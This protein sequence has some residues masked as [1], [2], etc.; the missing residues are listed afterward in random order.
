M[1]NDRQRPVDLGR[2]LLVTVVIRLIR[3]RT[4][5]V[6]LGLAVIVGLAVLGAVL[7]EGGLRVV[8]VA[9]A[10][11]VGVVLL[12][13]LLLR[14]VATFVVAKLAPPADLEA[15]QAA[16]DE[17]VE[18]LGLPLG[19]IS[20]PRFALR[21]RKGVDVEIDRMAAVLVELKGRLDD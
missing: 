11:V 10:V 3:E 1:S 13:G 17:A 20:A 9:I 12:T 18:Q 14:R 4:Q 21:L 8:L 19:P 7:V 6:I 5:P 16:F 15:N 2:S